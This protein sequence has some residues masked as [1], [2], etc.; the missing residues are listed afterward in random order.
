MNIFKEFWLDRFGR[1]ILIG[2][3]IT[4][5]VCASVGVSN[6][7]EGFIGNLLA[8]LTGNAL[9]IVVGLIVL[10]NYSRHQKTMNWLRAHKIT[11]DSIQQRLTSLFYTF[12]NYFPVFFFLLWR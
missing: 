10:D 6:D 4:I 12:I 3:T 2:T 11:L 7:S 8:E 9:A 5:I 1:R